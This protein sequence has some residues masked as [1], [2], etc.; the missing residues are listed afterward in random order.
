MRA[1]QWLIFLLVLTAPVSTSEMTADSVDRHS[2]SN[3]SIKSYNEAKKLNPS[4]NVPDQLDDAEELIADGNYEEALQYCDESI[5]SYDKAIEL[6]PRDAAAWNNKGIAL[7]K[8]GYY[9]EG[10]RCYEEAININPKYSE[11]WNNKANA[12]SNLGRH[13][14]SLESYY[15]AIEL[16]PEYASAWYNLGNELDEL[17]RYNEAIEAFD[18]VY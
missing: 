11:V 9:L 10:V 4:F 8:L 17:G 1:I 12:L 7:S 2:T 13:N 6:D 16:N 5:K 14:E 18:G 15:K 3:E